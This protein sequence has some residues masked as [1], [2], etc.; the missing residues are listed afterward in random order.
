MEERWKAYRGRWSQEWYISDESKSDDGSD[1]ITVDGV[2][3]LDIDVDDVP[4]HIVWFDYEE[5]A[6]TIARM[7]NEKSI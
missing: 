5:D 4:D 2:D 6:K 3:I 1:A 7:L